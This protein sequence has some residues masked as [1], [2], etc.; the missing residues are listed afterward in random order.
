MDQPKKRKNL[1]FPVSKLFV[2]FFLYTD[3]NTNVFLFCFNYYNVINCCFCFI[4]FIRQLILRYD[5]LYMWI[6]MIEYDGMVDVS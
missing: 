1:D 5:Y 4:S 2:C 6:W 3:I